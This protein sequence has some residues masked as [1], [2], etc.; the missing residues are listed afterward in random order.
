[1]KTPFDGAIRVG[2]R[3]IDEM[4]IAIRIEMDQLMQVEAAHAENVREAR[5]ERDVAEDQTLLSSYAYLERMRMER[6][7]LDEARAATDRRLGSLRTKAMAAY[8][9]LKAVNSAADSW[10]EEAE[11][12]VDSVE[13]RHLDDLSNAQFARGARRTRKV[14]Q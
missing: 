6:A 4:R 5:R 11:R 14:G 9:S 3:E 2:R 12:A 8:G 1:M 10:R 7:R 13:Q